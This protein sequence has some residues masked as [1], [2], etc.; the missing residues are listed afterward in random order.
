MA[1]AG[2]RVAILMIKDPNGQ[3]RYGQIDQKVPENAVG[4]VLVVHPDTRFR[5]TH[6]LNNGAHLERKYDLL[7]LLKSGVTEEKDASYLS[8]LKTSSYIAEDIIESGKLGRSL[9]IQQVAV[10]LGLSVNDVSGMLRVVRMEFAMESYSPDHR[11]SLLLYGQGLRDLLQTGQ[12]YKYGRVPEI[13]QRL[14]GWSGGSLAGLNC[15]LAVCS[16]YSKSL[17]LPYEITAFKKFYTERISNECGLS[18]LDRIL[19]ES[20]VFSDQ[21]E[22]ITRGYQSIYEFSGL[23]MDDAVATRHL[24]VLLGKFRVN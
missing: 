9:F 22:S 3:V 18:T 20:R 8:L 16:N 21:S 15:Y 24:N 14:K 2:E 10:E 17:L 23:C 4:K 13:I 5:L 11:K 6:G 19:I 1:K 7:E 12:K